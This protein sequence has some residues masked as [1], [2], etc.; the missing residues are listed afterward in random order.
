MAEQEEFFSPSHDRLL[1]IAV[2]AKYLAWAALIYFIIQAGLVIFQYQAD[3]HRMQLWAGSSA[4]MT[5]KE[6]FEFDP[7]YYSIDVM[8]DMVSALLRG[9]IYYVVLRGV[10]LALY[11]IVE[12]DVNYR[13]QER[14]E[15]AQ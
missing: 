9:A 8:V 15:P 14:K 11:M 6:L 7:L 3:L 2:W 5:L 4:I 12:T 13:E 10:S 1:T